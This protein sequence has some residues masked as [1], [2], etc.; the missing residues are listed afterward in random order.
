[1]IASLGRQGFQL[2]VEYWDTLASYG[3]IHTAKSGQR[4][5]FR[6]A[7]TVTIPGD[8]F[9]QQMERMLR[10]C[11]RACP[12][13]S[14]SKLEFV[15]AGCLS[16]R[17]F[18]QEKDSGLVKVHERWLH[19]ATVMGGFAF[20]EDVSETYTSLHAC[21]LLFRDI[22]E[23]LGDGSFA[24][25]DAQASVGQKEQQLVLA[26]Q[27]LTEYAHHHSTLALK[28][29]DRESAIVVTWEVLKSSMGDHSF[30][31]ALHD[32]STCSSLKDKLLAKDSKK[33][34]LWILSYHPAAC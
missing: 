9:A 22:V 15:K 8:Q 16:L 23:Q 21:K 24:N 33:P 28:T 5:R 31:V 25:H 30:E 19:R 1:M 7:A 12:Q 6:S 27:R 11:L 2:A 4:G 34:R 14:S 13:T 32:A 20:M 10:A 29:I 3:L 17:A 18:F 26:E